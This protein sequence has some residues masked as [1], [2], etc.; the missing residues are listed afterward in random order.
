MS[1]KK[2]NLRFITTAAFIAA[3]YAA[4]TFF[5]NFF[6]LSYGPIQVRFSEAL[7]VLPLFTPAAIPGLTIGCFIANK[8]SFNLL[9]M[10]F[11]TLATFIA[12]VLTYLLRDIKFKKLPL[13]AILPPVVINAVI[14]GLEIAFFFLPEGFTLYGFIISALQ[15]GLGQLIACYGLGVPLYLTLKS[16]NFS[17]ENIFKV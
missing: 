4:L 15:V 7:T 2:K 10:V 16:K 6:G 1:T 11:G 3:V 14:I 17:F 13:L 8:G 12:A 5:G 9:D